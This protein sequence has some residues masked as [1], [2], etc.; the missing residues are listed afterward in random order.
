MV[1][2]GDVP[3][4]VLDVRTP[5]EALARAVV[6]GFRTCA[7][8]LLTLLYTLPFEEDGGPLPVLPYEEEA[9]RAAG[10]GHPA[11]VSYGG[12]EHAAAVSLR[13][14]ETTFAVLLLLPTREAAQGWAAAACPGGGNAGRAGDGT[15]KRGGG[16]RWALTRRWQ[17]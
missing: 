15:A 14:G 4:L 6:H 9:L 10:E 3:A 12:R 1:R 2:E 5:Q 11:L 13:K 16:R 17:R 8:R 7:P